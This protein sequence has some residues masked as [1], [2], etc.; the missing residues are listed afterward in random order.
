MAAAATATA[1]A[2]GP[3]SDVE[4]VWAKERQMWDATMAQDDAA[5][6]SLWR[7]DFVGWPCGEKR[8]VHGPPPKFDRDTVRR[9]YVM[10]MKDAT[11]VPGLVS[12]FYHV[13]Q[14]DQHPDGRTEYFEFNMT[15]NW[16][17]TRGGWQILSGMCKPPEAM[18]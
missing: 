17:R 5:Y 12:T 3:N 8:P 16:V 1:A 14:R 11:T 15:H 9:S 13:R 2:A 10:D 4:A 6:L 18:P 7:Q